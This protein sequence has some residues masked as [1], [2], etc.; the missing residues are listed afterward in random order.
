MRPFGFQR[1]PYL[2]ALLVLYLSLAAGILGFPGLSSTAHALLLPTEI[3][4][5]N[6]AIGAGRGADI[7]KIQGFLE[8]K[9]VRQRLSDWGLSAQE[10]DARLSRLSEGQIHEIASQID[11]LIP[12]GDALGVIVLLLVIAILVVLLLQLT[13]HRV[14]ITK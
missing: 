9:L 13:G 8:R 3:A 11:R 6:S 2:L 14:I 4:P 5:E 12:G 7:R 10:V 1:H